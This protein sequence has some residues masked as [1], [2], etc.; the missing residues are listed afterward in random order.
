[1]GNKK[2]GAGENRDIRTQFVVGVGGALLY[3][4]MW[5]VWPKPHP[6][7]VLAPVPE[8]APGIVG[9]QFSLMNL[10]ENYYVQ[11]GIFVIFVCLAL[12]R[13]KDRRAWIYAFLSGWAFAGLGIFHW[14]R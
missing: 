8:N 13:R 11:L 7:S 4:V 10:L 1:M 3:A 6:R 5:F 9:W 14:L 2:H 12:F